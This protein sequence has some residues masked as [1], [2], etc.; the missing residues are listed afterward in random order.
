MRAGENRRTRKRGA[1][2]RPCETLLHFLCRLCPFHSF[3]HLNRKLQDTLPND[4]KEST[5]EVR[6]L[7]L[8]VFR[9]AE[10][11]LI[12]GF[13]GNEF[14]G[15]LELVVGRE[16]L[17]LFLFL[18]NDDFLLSK[19]GG[20]KV[21]LEFGQRVSGW[22]CFAV[23]SGRPVS[24][25]PPRNPWPARPPRRPT[26]IRLSQRRKLAGRREEGTR[27]P[28]LVF[29]ITTRNCLV[30]GGPSSRSRKMRLEKP[31]GHGKCDSRKFEVP[32]LSQGD[33]RYAGY[34]RRAPDLFR[35]LHLQSSIVVQPKERP[36][37]PT[38]SMTSVAVLTPC[39]APV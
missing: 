27:G 1:K 14:D 13:S 4:R 39:P 25:G 37:G 20:E 10:Q 21:Q 30:L 34:I 19:F 15:P 12:D 3:S 23:R 32:S 17:F 18:M 38:R 11:Q 31:S 36:A 7:D 28:F 22:W 26:R 33:G 35:K 8:A 24:H 16:R 6:R 9:E 5:F 29:C 2:K